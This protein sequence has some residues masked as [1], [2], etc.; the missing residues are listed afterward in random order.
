MITTAPP[1]IDK[2]EGYSWAKIATSTGL[3]IGSTAD[4]RFIAKGGQWREDKPNR[5]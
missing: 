5:I 1:I 2:I 3:K 4:K